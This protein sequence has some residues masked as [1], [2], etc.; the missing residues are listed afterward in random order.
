M[1]VAEAV[2]FPY[3]FKR[4][5]VTGAMRYVP[6]RLQIYLPAKT[7]LASVESNETLAAPCP[8]SR[9]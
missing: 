9:R 1:A 8:A 7:L 3:S 2:G 6:A 5:R 4:V